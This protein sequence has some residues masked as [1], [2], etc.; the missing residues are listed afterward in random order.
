MAAFLVGCAHPIVIG[1]TQT[2]ARYAESLI[3]K[4]VAY[5][6]S[7]SERSKE[8]T[9]DGGGGDSV[10]YFPYR[11]L[12]KGIRDALR[13]VYADVY[14]IRSTK[15]TTAIKS[16]NISYI[17]IP[18]ISTSSSSP[19]IFTWPPTK[20]TIEISCNVFDADGNLLTQ[21]H[22]KGSGEAEFSEFVP[23]F[24]LA[25]RRAANDLSENFK[26]A[27]SADQKLR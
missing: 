16:G 26:R 8:V 20:F 21:V 23:E 11:D 6:L 18:E 5:V 19:S 15:D 13:A 24:G 1:P 17:F 7:E 3:N 9:T 4:N 14:V 10:S 27:V 22:A 12:E 25:G 2:P